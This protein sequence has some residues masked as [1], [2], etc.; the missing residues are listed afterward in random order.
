M[1]DRSPRIRGI[2][3]RMT[4]SWKKVLNYFLNGLLYTVPVAIVLYIIFQL[5][6]FLDE[7]LIPVMESLGMEKYRFQ[8]MGIIVLIVLITG[9]GYFGSTLIARPVRRW[10]N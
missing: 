1:D 6:I 2:I 3:A 9:M 10:I 8:G 5:F 4:S 7:L